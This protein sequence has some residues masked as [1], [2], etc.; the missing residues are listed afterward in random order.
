[1][2]TWSGEEFRGVI[3]VFVSKHVSPMD[4]SSP[5]DDEVNEDGVIRWQPFRK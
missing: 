3:S 1:V 5:F 2:D 4:V